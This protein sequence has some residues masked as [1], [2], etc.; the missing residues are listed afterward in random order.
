MQLDFDK[1]DELRRGHLPFWRLA[2]KVW[3]KQTQGGRL[4]LTE[5]P[6][7][8]EALETNY[9]T[10]REQVN[11]VVVDQCM[12]GLRDP[13]SKKL[14]KKATAL[15]V[16]DEKFAEELARVQRCNH[17]PDQHEQIKGHVYWNGKWQRRSTLAAAWPNGLADHILAAAERTWK[18]AISACVTTWR[19]AEP[20]NGSEWLTVP[21][22]PEGGVLTLEEVLRR[23]LNQMGAAGDRYDYVTFEGEARGLPRRLRTTLA[24]LHVQLPDLIVGQ[25]I[26]HVEH[27]VLNTTMIPDVKTVSGDSLIEV[28]RFL[29]AHLGLVIRRSYHTANL[30]PQMPSSQ[31]QVLVMRERWYATFGPPDELITDAGKEFC[32]SVQRLNDLFAVRHDVVPD[33]AK[34]RM[35]HVERHGAILKLMLMRMV[36]ELKLDKLGEMQG[37][38][39]AA[40]A[41]KNRII[42]SSGVSPLQAVTGR[43]T[44]IPSSL[45]AQLVS[46]HVKF[47]LNEDLEKDEALRRAERIR[48]S[49]IEACHWIDAHEGLRRALNAKSKPPRLELLREGTIVYCY[50]P[51]TNRRGLARRL[52]DNSSWSGP[53]VVVCVERT[54]GAPKRVWVRMKTRVKCYPLEKLRLATCD[55]MVSAEFISGALKE[56]QEELNK[57]VTEVPE[58]KEEKNVKPKTPPPKT[59]QPKTPQPKT[60]Q[61][62]MSQP[63]TPNAGAG[64][65][66]S[67]LPPWAGRVAD[68]PDARMKGQESSSSSNS[69]STSTAQDV[70][71][72][73]EAKRKELYSDV[74]L[75][76]RKQPKKGEPH[77]MSFDNKRK[78]FETLAKEFQAPTAMEEA[79]VRAK[80]ETAFEQLKKVRKSYRKEDKEKS[81]AEAAKGTQRRSRPAFMVMPEE[82]EKEIDAS[83][84]LEALWNELED[85][86]TLW[87]DEVASTTGANYVQAIMEVAEKD[88]SNCSK[89]VYEAKLV[90]GKQRLEYKWQSLSPEWQEAFKEPILKAVKVYFDHQAISGVAKDVVIDPRKILTSRFVL[91]NKGAEDLA[92]AELKG[93]WIFG[94]HRDAELGKYPTMAPTAS[95]LAHNLL[96]FVAVQNGWEVHYEDVSA[97]F[98]QGKRLPPGREVYVKIPFGYP[99]YVNAYIKETLGEDCRD[100]LLKLDKGWLWSVRKSSTVATDGK[101]KFCGRF[102]EQDKQTREF[103]YSMDDYIQKTPNVPEYDG[104]KEDKLTDKERLGLSSVLGQLNWAAR[105][106]RYDLSYGASHCQQMVGIGKKEAIDWTRK[107]WRRAQ[108]KV[109]LKVPKLGCPVEDLVVIS[110]SGAAFAAQP[111]GGS[112]GGVTCILAHPSILEGDAPAAI[113]EAQSMKIQR[114]VRC[115]MSAELSMAAEAFEHGDYIRAVLAELTNSH[116]ELRRW[117]WYASRWRHYIVIDAKTGYDVLNSECMTPDRKIMIDASVLR[118]ALMEEGSENYVRWIPGKEMVSD[119]LTK[120]LDNHVL[121]KVMMEGRWQLVDTPAAQK[122]R[123]EAAERKRRYVQQRKQVTSP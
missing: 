96:N 21:V 69:S 71:M 85:H 81:R 117:K 41:S 111:Q 93:R 6:E 61:P 123:A 50:D 75:A 67:M 52:Q 34:W 40:V 86:A 32:G 13:V 23:Q 47:K 12:F 7:Q 60:P 70:R 78:L 37:A 59:P 16:N 53:A 121:A 29:I 94:G 106:G 25:L 74:P 26:N 48:A 91:T 17:R 5:Q 113:V 119:G 103:T 97:A 118:E 4:A 22:E 88:A 31:Q 80:M 95:L 18:G 20:Q 56:V 122:L 73:R 84:G 102:E 72:E 120:W 10:G 11:R 116:F 42:G 51:P 49:A 33:Q 30:A 28:G 64:A 112:Q 104:T 44:P 35:G 99:S 101:T 24:H 3:D 68:P 89:A 54:N 92:N 108:E 100:D 105:Q 15:D 58:T 110:A 45:L 36:A 2:R 55:E 43:S 1:L 39:T 115:S 83:G 66:S 46:G 90:T 19:L 114:V 76:L 38:V 79:Q 109:E 14:Y 63:Q 27:R 62:K 57:G 9:M 65:S 87:D 8:S 77:E 98:L 107:L 82:L